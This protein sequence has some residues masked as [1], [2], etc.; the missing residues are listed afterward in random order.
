[1]GRRTL[2]SVRYVFRN[3]GRPVNDSRAVPCYVLILRRAGQPDRRIV[4]DSLSDAIAAAKADAA[5]LAGIGSVLVSPL[6]DVW[7]CGA[8]KG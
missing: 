6:L 7:R 8:E 3:M 5:W 2:P 1:M 4:L